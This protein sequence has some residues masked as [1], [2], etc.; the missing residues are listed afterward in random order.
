MKC[1]SSYEKGSE[2]QKQLMKK[3]ETIFKGGNEEGG[4]WLESAR[5][6]SVVMVK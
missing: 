3:L 1:E 2:R 4:V 5:V 6:G